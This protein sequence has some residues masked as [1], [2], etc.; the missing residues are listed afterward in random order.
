MRDR[1][2]Y[3]EQNGNAR[4]RIEIESETFVQSQMNLFGIRYVNDAYYNRQLKEWITVAYINREEAWQVFLPR[5]KQQAQGFNQLF[6]TAENETDSF[7]KVMRLNTAVNYSRSLDFQNADTFGQLLNPSKMNEEFSAVRSQIARLPELLDNNRRNA[8]VFIDCPLDFESLI[9]TAFSRE[10]SSLG[11]PVANS[12]NTAA[13][14]CSITVS[15][16]RQQRELGVFYHPSLQA[17]ISSRAGTL[18]TFAI[19]GETASAVTPDVAK[20]RAYQALADKVRERFRVE[21]DN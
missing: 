19:E 21:F 2:H 3:T 16:G 20:R 12:R 5:V 11:F 10:L 14:I 17:V 1:I 6:L 7:R 18:F 4:T 13:A 15:E 8:S 9:V